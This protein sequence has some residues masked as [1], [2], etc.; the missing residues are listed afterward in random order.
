MTRPRKTLPRLD[1]NAHILQP[2]YGHTHRSVTERVGPVFR[3]ELQFIIIKY[4]KT[5]QNSHETWSDIHLNITAHLW[6]DREICGQ[7]DWTGG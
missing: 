5:Q 2:I 3:N 7:A 1:E 6:Q 4:K